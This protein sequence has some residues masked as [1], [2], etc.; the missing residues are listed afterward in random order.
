MATTIGIPVSVAR[1]WSRPRSR[2][3]P[4][5][6]TIPRSMMSAASSGGVFD[7][8]SMVQGIDTVV[9]VSSPEAAELVKLL[10]NTFRSVNDTAPSRRA[11]RSSGS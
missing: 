10:E 5:V 7:A 4:P 11:T 3:P 8:Y 9:P 1:R 2:A 6:I